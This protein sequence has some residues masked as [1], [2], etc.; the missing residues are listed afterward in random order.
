M[1]LKRLVILTLLIAI[2]PCWAGERDKESRDGTR[3][4]TNRRTDARGSRDVSNEDLPILSGNLNDDLRP[5]PGYSRAA[6]KKTPSVDLMPV[7]GTG[8][9]II[10]KF[11]D[12]VKA[13]CVEGKVLSY[14]GVD[15]SGLDRL[16][17]TSN[18]EVKPL[19]DISL[20]RLAAIEDKAVNFSNKA[21]PDL[22]SMMK[23]SGPRGRILQ[24]ARQLNDMAIVEYVEFEQS[25]GPAMQGETIACCIQNATGEQ[26][27]C[28]A[29]SLTDCIALNGA[30]NENATGPSACSDISGDNIA[31][32][33]VGACCFQDQLGAAVCTSDISPLD[34]ALDVAFIN[35]SFNGRGTF[36]IQD[37]G[38]I[39]CDPRGAC[40]ID[41]GIGQPI[42]VQIS[43]EDC[44]ARGEDATFTTAGRD[45]DDE[46]SDPCIPAGCG[47]DT[48]G[49]CFVPTPFP[50]GGSDPSGN[51][52][53]CDLDN[54]CQAVC[55]L[56]PECCDNDLDN[57][58]DWD[59]RCAAI[60]EVFRADSRDDINICFGPPPPPNGPCNI[61]GTNCFA[62]S[63]TAGC[64]ITSCC[65]SVCS[66]DPSCCDDSLAWDQACVD[67]A[68][69][70]C[71]KST[72]G[73]T[74]DFFEM[75]LQG[76][77]TA[78]PYVVIPEQL[79][80][81]MF[82][83]AC[84]GAGRSTPDRPAFGL[85]PPF[86]VI[87]GF[88]GEGFD[89]AGLEAVG[90][91]LAGLGKGDITMSR[92]KD[93][94]IGVLDF[95]A[96]IQDRPDLGIH[97]DLVGQVTIMP[98]NRTMTLLPSPI[99]D[100]DH[101]TAVLGI[102]GAN[103]TNNLGMI[104]M[105]PNADVFF[106]PVST[107]EDGGRT[108]SAMLDVVENFDPGDVVFIALGNGQFGTLGCGNFLSVNSHWLLTRML[109]N[110]GITVVI[111]ADNNACD[112]IA[113][114]QV[115]DANTNDSGAIVVGACS[116]GFPYT[117][118]GSSNHCT[119]CDNETGDKVHVSAWGAAVATLGTGNM[120]DGGDISDPTNNYTNSFGNTSAAGAQITALVARYQGLAKQMYGMPFSPGQIRD[121]DDLDSVGAAV[122]LFNPELLW[123]QDNRIGDALGTPNGLE[124]LGDFS[125]AEDPNTIVG[126]PIAGAAAAWAVVGPHFGEGARLL[127]NVAVLRGKHLFG[128]HFA[129]GSNDQNYL[130]I[131]SEFTSRN[132]APHPT[133]PP[134][135]THRS[136]RY[137]A[138]GQ[139]TDIVVDFETE[140]SV[141]DQLEIQATIS[142]TTNNVTNF[143]LII[144]EMYDWT[145]RRW[146]F[147]GFDSTVPFDAPYIFP[148]FFGVQR[149]VRSTDDKVKVRIYTIGL[150]NLGTTGAAGA[151]RSTYT[152]RYDFVAID[153]GV[154]PG[155]NQIEHPLP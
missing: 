77:L 10:V 72:S 36:C 38:V 15:M 83:P 124:C 79:V 138:A 139:I 42:C 76:Y 50:I 68:N 9:S 141:I 116:P 104:S 29:I 122:G 145:A 46:D 113:N 80:D 132:D 91:A 67:L 7:N 20:E 62:T 119:T 152:V 143:N 8:G 30:P 21:Q 18:L 63:T 102:V 146:D 125:F 16:I 115:G 26:I 105:A 108:L 128:T 35:S 41:I 96:Y 52:P 133:S 136:I 5:I 106:F 54:C 56:I 64:S 12:G 130:I 37:G 6:M 11:M 131:E 60:A 134:D 69:A 147:V 123:A 19:F 43:K 98:T 45:C 155:G 47:D 31:D 49:N 1:P 95:S 99:T 103:S 112:L 140:L 13:R 78:D 71:P 109:T 27:Q 135:P 57:P 75:G 48:A 53:F 118:L 40:C 34:C 33:C 82:I 117:R 107:L 93:I 58:G 87:S 144:V 32:A 121:T 44:L 23:I 153:I 127:R 100:P 14:A 28:L 148:A 66:I 59:E 86:G 150:G 92:G 39:N 70:L 129:L 51:S 101:G 4:V 73:S 114:P 2:T 65:R 17:R 89:I 81:G 25:I 90:S 3:S 85:S 149:F 55:Q 154:I 97:E 94:R 137:L 142:S 22:A 126:F 74:P 88:S 151:V 111:P 120:W 24:A 110:A 61:S 84:I